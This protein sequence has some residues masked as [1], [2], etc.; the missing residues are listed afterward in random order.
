MMEKCRLLSPRASSTLSRTNESLKVAETVRRFQPIKYMTG[1][2][3]LYL[4]SSCVC[5][6][7]ATPVAFLLS[8]AAK[9]RQGVEGGTG[10]KHDRKQKGM[11]VNCI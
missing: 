8:Y 11:L 4:L 9:L 5:D 1:R 3:W 2:N 6:A 7:A 10:V